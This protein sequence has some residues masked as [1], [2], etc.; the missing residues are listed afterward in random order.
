MEFETKHSRRQFIATGSALA[1]A[2]AT[3]LTPNRIAAQSPKSQPKIVAF[4]KFLQDLSYDDLA[5]KI[6]ELGFDGVEA[7]VRNKGHVLPERVEEDLPKMVEALKRHDV[8]IVAMATD[9]KAAD[10]LSEKVLKTAVGLGVKW[11]RMGFYKYDLEAP[12][13]KQLEDLKPHF[14][15]LADL[16]RQLGVQG[17]SLIHI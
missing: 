8:E 16:N 7:T 3:G 15:E 2:A 1:A 4:T 17:L 9:V 13:L 14:K 12:I 6:K 5:A 10:A 11:Y